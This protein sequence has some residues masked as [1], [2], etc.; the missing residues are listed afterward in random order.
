MVV[1]NTEN[2]NDENGWNKQTNT[3]FFLKKQERKNWKQCEIW[4]NK[5]K[6]WLKLKLKSVCH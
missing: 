5:A 4:V 1:T 2:N 6:V 3:D